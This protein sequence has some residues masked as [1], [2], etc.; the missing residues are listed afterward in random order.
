[1]LQAYGFEFLGTLHHLE[2]VGLLSRARATVAADLLGGGGA[3]AAPF[4][5]L[6]RA[7]ALVVDDVDPRTPRDAAFVTSG[8]AP[9]SCR[10]VEALATRGGAGLA[11]A[12][13]GLAGAPHLRYVPRAQSREALANALSAVP[14]PLAVDPSS[15]APAP[16]ARPD[17]A[18]PVLVAFFVGGVTRAEIAALRFLSRRPDFP[19]AVVVAATAVVGGA[20][21]LEGLA[22]DVENRLARDGGPSRGGGPRT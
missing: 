8:Y 21:L 19:F 17:G 11:A 13:P 14:T 12:L 10:L 9:L 18:K 5:T 3:D 2:R 7:L 6:R 20:G 4:A 22:F 16:P 15:L 1:M